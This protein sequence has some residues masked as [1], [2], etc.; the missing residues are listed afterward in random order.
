MADH[1]FEARLDQLFRDYA[2]EGVR[3]IDRHA[4]AHALVTTQPRGFGAR[5][6]L[7]G[8]WRLL[9]AAALSIALIG[10]GLALVGDRSVQPP[11]PATLTPTSSG[12]LRPG[13]TIIVQVDTPAGSEVRAYAPDGMWTVLAISLHGR[14]CP[15]FSPDGRSLAYLAAFA[16]Q[17][18]DALYIA[19]SDGGEPRVVWH[20]QRNLQT[21]NQVIWS[22]NSRF[23]T[24]TQL[25]SSGSPPSGQFVIGDR[26]DGSSRA[27][28]GGG[29]ELPGGFAW[30]PDGEEFAVVARVADAT[31]AIDILSRDGSA[32][33]RVVTAQNL[34][35]AAWAPDGRTI[36]YTATAA[37]GAQ[38]VS[39]LWLL[40]LDGSLPRRIDGLSAVQ[41]GGLAWSPDGR[42]LAA[43]TQPKTGPAVAVILDRGAK[44]FG[45]IEFA[46]SGN[47]FMT[48]SPDASAILFSTGG[49][50]AGI[51]P[52]IY[53]IDGGPSWTIALP[54]ASYYTQCPLAWQ[55]AGRG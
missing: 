49:D 1:V 55:A 10:A 52:T 32:S 17:D 37:A 48:W 3:P 35:S 31:R 23:V 51:G 44:E 15:T 16:G 2:E 6:R 28:D 46:S 53:P 24:A 5:A 27:F 30:S 22:P 9:L 34:W 20:G 42:Y 13:G 38:E 11:P 26:Q 12:I 8:P 7:A 4:I 43:L 54:S 14:S 21:S 45:R 29:G 19:N 33:R 18:R 25:L 41:F 50:Q 40:D 39:E 47:L 36:A